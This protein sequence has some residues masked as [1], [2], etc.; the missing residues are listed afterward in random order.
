MDGQGSI[1]DLCRSLGASEFEV[2]RAVFQLVQAGHA[3]IRAPRLGV[4]AAVAVYNDA[5]SLLLRELDAIDHGDAVR[6]QLAQRAAGLPLGKVLEGAGPADDGRFDVD[7]VA[8][9][10]AGRPDARALEEVLGNWLHEH[11]SYALFLTRP[12]LKR[13]LE[14]AKLLEPIAPRAD[15]ATKRRP[16]P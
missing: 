5:V 12:H 15:R 1:E 11:A 4:R 14:S 10:V 3:S 7:R 6:E 13:S 2:T 16:A 9:N 8:T